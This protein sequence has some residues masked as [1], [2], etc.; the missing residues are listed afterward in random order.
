MH[1]ATA[2][3]S[4]TV[5]ADHRQAHLQERD[6]DDAPTDKAIKTTCADS[7]H[8]KKRVKALHL[9]SALTVSGCNIGSQW[10]WYV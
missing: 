7:T 9:K 8:G 2:K 1:L 10:I 4:V 6:L 5:K 3:P